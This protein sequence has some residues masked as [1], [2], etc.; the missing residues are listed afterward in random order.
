MAAARRDL[1]AALTG[2]AGRD[3]FGLHVTAPTWLADDPGGDPLDALLC[4]VQAAW[5]AGLLRDEPRRLAGLDLSEGWIADPAVV[6]RLAP[7]GRTAV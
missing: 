7:A 1:L 6:A 3:R 4:A 5:A 2:E